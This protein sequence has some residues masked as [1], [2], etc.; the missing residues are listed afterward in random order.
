MCSVF[1]IP[2]F[3]SKR[4]TLDNFETYAMQCV[5]HSCPKGKG[6]DRFLVPS[7]CQAPCGAHT[8]I[9]DSLSNP[10]RYLVITLLSV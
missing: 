10:M 9:F 1:C 2:S 6:A 7:V 8:V 3:S 5:L 4:K